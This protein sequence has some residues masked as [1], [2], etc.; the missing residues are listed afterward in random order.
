M[1]ATESPTASPGCGLSSS[2]SLSLRMI[3]RRPYS[4]SARRRSP[5]AKP[6]VASQAP[7]SRMAASR[8]S[9]HPTDSRH[10]VVTL[11]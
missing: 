5:A 3:T 4:T 11:S 6:N 2:F 7:D 9:R 1:T 10:T 8:F